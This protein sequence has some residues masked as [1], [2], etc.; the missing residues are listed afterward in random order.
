MVVKALIDLYGSRIKQIQ[1]VF[2]KSN[3][4]YQVME[5]SSSSQ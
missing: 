2:V 3:Q 1:Y 4:A 5:Q